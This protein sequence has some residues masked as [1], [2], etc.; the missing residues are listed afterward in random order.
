MIEIMEIVN[1][2]RKI[3]LSSVGIEQQFVWKQ[4]LMLLWGE[5]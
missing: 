4:S 1:I 2:T 3:T 5:T